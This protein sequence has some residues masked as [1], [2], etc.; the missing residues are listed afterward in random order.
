MMTKT[1][2]RL[3]PV[4][5]F[6]LGVG[7]G[8]LLL[9]TTTA[10]QIAGSKS[11]GA[12]DEI[13]VLRYHKLRKGTF[14]E[15]A[16]TVSSAQPYFERAG[17]RQVGMWQVIYPMLPGQTVRESSEFDEAYMLNRYASVEHWQATRQGEVEKIAGNGPDASV[18]REA[19][20]RRQRVVL[21]SRITVLKGSLAESPVFFH[22]A[23]PK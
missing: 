19:L 15:F 1:T 12:S 16:S 18:A 22:P 23:L 10:A 20:A 9:K 4:L 7:C 21:E 5:C 2:S 13:L 17:S 11:A 6:C 3:V 14:A 8:S